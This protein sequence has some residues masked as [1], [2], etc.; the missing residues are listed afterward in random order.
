MAEYYEHHE[1]GC[2]CTSRKRRR[3]L[4]S[5]ALVAAVSASAACA[6]DP[7][8][9]TVTAIPPG[10]AV[11]LSGPGHN[12]ILG[13][14]SLISRSGYVRTCDGNTAYLLPVTP[15]S[16]ELMIRLFGQ[17]NGGVVSRFQFEHQPDEVLRSGRQTECRA[18]GTFTFE[19]VADGDYY[20]ITDVTWLLRL[21]RE[22]AALGTSVRAEEG[23]LIEL[24]LR[25]AY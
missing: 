24:N 17:P 4:R 19:H 15:A 11:Q 7:S 25:H 12:T 22:G 5:L 8:L 18:D 21:V 23:K 14:A 1:R 16:T 13:R 9:L 20:A 10:A 3:L 6:P 2:F